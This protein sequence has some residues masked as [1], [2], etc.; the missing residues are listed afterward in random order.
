VRLNRKSIQK[1][2]LPSLETIRTDQRS[3]TVF[4]LIGQFNREFTGRPVRDSIDPALFLESDFELVGD[5]LGGLFGPAL[6]LAAAAFPAI[7]MCPA[8]DD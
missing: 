7:Y 6:D 1:R 8:A 3:R 2:S 5:F 4:Y